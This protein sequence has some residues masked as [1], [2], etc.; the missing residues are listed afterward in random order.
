MPGDVSAARA[1]VATD[2]ALEMH[3]WMVLSRVLEERLLALYRQ[4]RIRGRL[5]TGRGQEAIPAGAALAVRPDDVMCIMHRDM[6][7]HLARGTTPETV[8]LHYFGKATGPSRGRDGDIHFAEWSRNNFPM[9]SHLPDSLPVAVGIAMASRLREEG[10]VVVAFCGEGSTSTGAWH[11]SLNFAAVFEAP[12]VFIVENNQY[13]YSTPVE[14]Q[15]RARALVDRGPGYGIPAV[16][17]DGNDALAV[18]CVVGE[19]VG[20]ARLGGGPTM[21]EAHTMR[22]DGHAVHDDASYVPDTLLEEWRRRDPIDSLA[23]EL[24]GR[25]VGEMR[26]QEDWLAA[27]DAVEIAVNRAWD[28]PDPTA[29]DVA[30]GVFA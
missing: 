18:H 19:A 24:R 20:R 29:D 28:A 15:Y 13:A 25:G 16:A 7:A 6:A 26:L 12:A 21:I 14:R 30:G 2:V 3:R 22:M 9:V 4:G 8:L 5:L 11:E 10:I 27:R 23:H 1:G 17:V